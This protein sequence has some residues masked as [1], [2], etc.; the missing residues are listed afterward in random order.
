MKRDELLSSQ[1]GHTAGY[2]ARIEMSLID[3]MVTAIH[4][5]KFADESGFD[6]CKKTRYLSDA[7]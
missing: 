6:R 4:G 5:I 2:V 3:N 7:G 1:H